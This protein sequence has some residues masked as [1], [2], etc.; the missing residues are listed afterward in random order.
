M[1]KGLAIAGVLAM[2]M[3]V[4][5]Q[6]KVKVG[7]PKVGDKTK[8]KVEMTFEVGANSAKMDANITKS[9]KKWDKDAVETL[10]EWSDFR[11]E[12]DGSAMDLPVEPFK[13][14]LTPEGA[15]KEVSGGITGSDP[16]RTYLLIHFFT[17]DKELG[18][19]E[20][21][22]KTYI[23]KDGVFE[24]KIETVY[25]GT[26]EVA[27]KKLHKFKQ[28]LN[29]VKGDEMSSESTFWISDTGEILKFEVNYKKLIIPQ[30][31]GEFANGTIKASAAS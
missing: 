6:D 13:V 16:L 14:A 10:H 29:E 8:L 27:G 3:T 24:F 20:K 18:K 9:I 21:W 19:G 17:P 23:K 11:L 26:E 15:I 1:L 12:L 2:T 22:E 5:A 28:K 30:A 25:E 31:N 4:M 7:A